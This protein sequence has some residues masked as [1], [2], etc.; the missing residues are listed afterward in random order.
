[1]HSNAL[2]IWL[3]LVHVFVISSLNF[4]LFYRNYCL[5]NDYFSLQPL[6]Y[7]PHNGVLKSENDGNIHHSFIHQKYIHNLENQEN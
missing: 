6:A 2:V 1:M 7:V 5:I 4:K 3:V